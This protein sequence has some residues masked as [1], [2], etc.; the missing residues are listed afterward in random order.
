MGKGSAVVLQW[1]HWSIMVWL[2]AG[3]K[4]GLLTAREDEDILGMGNDMGRGLAERFKR[5]MRQASRVGWGDHLFCSQPV[6]VL[7]QSPDWT[8]P[9]A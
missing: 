1:F 4:T 5:P 8:G 3:G 7:S 2:A 9:P 6:P